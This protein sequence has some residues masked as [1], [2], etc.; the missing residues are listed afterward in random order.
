MNAPSG[1]ERIATRRPVLIAFAGLPGSGKSTLARRLSELIGAVYL[2][3]DSIEQAIKSTVGSFGDIGD[4]GYRVAYAVGRDNLNAGHS[5]VADSVNPLRLSRDAWRGIADDADVVAVE[6]EITCSDSAEHRRRVES[7][8]VDIAGM[9]LP[10]WEE[11]VVREYEPWDRD[12]LV[13]DTAGR[14]IEESLQEL[15]ALFRATAEG[16]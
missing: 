2:H 9:R 14:T 1:E 16:L 4:A 11:I 15:L 3:V 7:R 13:V 5:V 8:P 12:R 6:I 10:T